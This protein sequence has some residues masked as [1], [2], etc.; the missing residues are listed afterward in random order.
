MLET[1][2]RVQSVSP[3]QME[4]GFWGGKGGVLTVWE[5]QFLPLTLPAFPGLPHDISGHQSPV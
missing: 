3:S 1:I 5:P 4:Q 2:M